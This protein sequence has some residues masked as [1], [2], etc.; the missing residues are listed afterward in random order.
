MSRRSAAWAA[1]GTHGKIALFAFACA[2]A[3]L[4][5]SSRHLVSAV[6]TPA[7]SLAAASGSSLERQQQYASVLE[8]NLKQTDGRSLFFIP[9]APPPPPP[10]P[11]A[12]VDDRPPPP[13]PPPA[14]YGGPSIIAM[15]NDTVWFENGK[16]LGVGT[17]EDGLKVVSLNAPWSAVL[18]WKGVE[19]T[20]DLFKKDRV[21]APDPLPKPDAGSAANPEAQEPRLSATT[22][23]GATSGAPTLS[24]KE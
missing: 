1:M 16:K 10:P 8:A 15:L 14:R 23:P 11:A 2:A 13:P 6:A 3:A 18:E 9:S 20:V 17:A 22:P 24:G 4:L 19:F 21:V 7:A 5:V 12:V